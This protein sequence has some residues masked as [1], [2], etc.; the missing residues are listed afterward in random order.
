MELFVVTSCANKEASYAQQDDAER[1]CSQQGRN[2]A[3]QKPEPVCVSSRP[4][5]RV[6]SPRARLNKA[7]TGGLR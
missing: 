4:D 5:L 3:V 2:S 1:L 6:L 7:E